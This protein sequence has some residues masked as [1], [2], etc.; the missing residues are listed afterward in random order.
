[1]L[2]YITNLVYTSHTYSTEYG[3]ETDMLA[4]RTRSGRIDQ[5]RVSSS[6]LCSAEVTTVAKSSLSLVT[7][8]L[9]LSH[10]TATRDRKADKTKPR[11]NE[12]V[13]NYVA[14]GFTATEVK[15]ICATGDCRPDVSQPATLTSAQALHGESNILA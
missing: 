14:C 5:S 13:R 7:K 9:R 6:V 12:L 1:M 3:S 15:V 8:W 11:Q 4:K 10:A 2:E